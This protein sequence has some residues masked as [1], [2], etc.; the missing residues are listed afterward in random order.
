MDSRL[1]IS[2]NLLSL[3]SEYEH[4]QE[5]GEVKYLTDTEYYQIVAYYGEECDYD[6]A[7][8]TI[9]R[10]I[11]QFS[12]R[13]DFLCIKARILIK[14]GLFV[15]ASMVI[16]RAETVAPKE[17][18]VQLLK[19]RVHIHLGH[20][21]K[22]H[23][24]IEE[25]KAEA[26]HSDLEDIYLVEA[27]LYEYVQ[28]YEMMFQCIKKALHINP[29]SEEALYKMNTAI[30]QSKNYQE[31][32]LIH[33]VI[34]NN[35]PYN[36]LAWFNLGHAYANVQEYDKAIEAFEFVY[37]INPHFEQ[38]YLDCAQ[39][40]YDR[41]K[42]DMALE[43]Y[44]EALEIFGSGFD[45]LMSISSCQFEQGMIDKAKR[46]LFKAIELDAY[47]DEA[48]F[49]LA[50]CYMKTEDWNSAVK[51]LRKAIFI[52]KDVEE[53]FHALGKSYHEI[54]DS[55]RALYYYQKA[56]VKGCEQA[57]YWE[58]YIAFLICQGVSKDAL[59]ELEVADRYTFSYRLEYL[60]AACYIDLG[61]IKKGLS[62]LEEA[63]IESFESH[64]VLNILPKKISKH[65]EV[66][67]IITYYNNS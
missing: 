65:K 38:A 41:R 9:D 33:Q 18:E 2:P 26:L 34:V 52:E 56:A 5:S 48:F 42:Y 7:L 27:F 17:L 57:N 64:I 8:E 58:D 21:N 36:H 35:Y 62:V 53:Y 63:L 20:F 47:D 29:N 49:L 6:R 1:K 13:A 4:Q 11:H 30:E 44:E 50:K 16:S 31:G 25:L 46:N 12:Y 22:A 37:I 60:K 23:V 40:C 32:I 10:A 14:Q 28:E 61:E 59:K 24:L 43:I 45:L 55:T 66:I 67:S 3:I 54:N 51:V 19:T 39:L 15:K